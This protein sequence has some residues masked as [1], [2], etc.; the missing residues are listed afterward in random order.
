HL[1]Q[2]RLAGAVAPDDADGL[3]LA[4]LET[5]VAQRPEFAE[6]GM[7][8]PAQHPLHARQDHLLEPVGGLRIDLVALGQA[9]DADAGV[10]RR[11]RRNPCASA[12][13][14]RTLPMRTG[15][16]PPRRRPDATTSATRPRPAR[17]GMPRR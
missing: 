2:A 9:L 15:T 3:A 4:H 5:D 14:R 10:F 11:H 16:T 1:Q 12:G 7:R 17:P 8:R 13:T 6:I